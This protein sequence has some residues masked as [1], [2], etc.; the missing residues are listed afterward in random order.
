MNG[1]DRVLDTL[2]VLVDEHP[3]AMA[4][5]AGAL[6]FLVLAPVLRG[7]AGGRT[8][9]QRLFTPAQRTAAF[10]R[11][12]GRCEH[13]TMLGL[14]CSARPTHADH[15]Y[16]W[17]KGGASTLSN[18]QALCARHNLQKGAK[19][20]SAG[21]MWRLERRRRRYFPPGE[22]ARVEWRLGVHA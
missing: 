12:G 17:S 20:P 2:T 21:Y 13:K 1:I 15:I 11:A 8:D 10:T 14:R 6:A 18:C 5:L 9:P 19:V 3:V 22:P 4:V 7:R 16:P